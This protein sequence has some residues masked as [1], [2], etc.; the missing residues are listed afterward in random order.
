VEEL[1]YNEFITSLGSLDSA[2]IIDRTELDRRLQ[3]NRNIE[4]GQ[5]VSDE[6]RKLAVADYVPSTNIRTIHELARHLNEIDSTRSVTEFG[7]GS[8]FDFGNPK[9]PDGYET[10]SVTAINEPSSLITINDGAGNSFTV[11]FTEF[12]AQFSALKAARFSDPLNTADGVVK[13]LG[14][15]LS[16]NKSD[17]WRKI[18]YANGEFRDSSS[19]GDGANPSEELKK[20]FRFFQQGDTLVEI[21]KSAPGYVTFVR[22]EGF[23]PEKVEKDKVTPATSK[24]A[25]RYERVGYEKL[26]QVLRTYECEPTRLSHEIGG[27]DRKFDIQEE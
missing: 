9:R 10:F 23:T 21:V 19:V 15:E 25:W 6:D 13:T 26:Y 16:G 20:P 1:D 24:K 3:I 17:A 27:I 18:A 22:H 8:S 14:S 2:E 12:Y 4:S 7:V 11:S 5:Q